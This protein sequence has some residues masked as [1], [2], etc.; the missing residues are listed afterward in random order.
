MLRQRDTTTGLMGKII[1]A[2]KHVR[3]LLEEYGF[4]R[5]RWWAG[6]KCLFAHY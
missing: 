2:L 4:W 3:T 6:V 5:H 1:A